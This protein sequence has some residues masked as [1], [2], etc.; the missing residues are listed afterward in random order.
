MTREKNTP[1][2]Q[3]IAIERAV[4]ATAQQE[5]DPLDLSALS[6]NLPDNTA[7]PSGLA[8]ALKTLQLGPKLSDIE[9]K[10][11]IKQGKGPAILPLI[12][13]VPHL[14]TP[15]WK[16]SRCKSN[17]QNHLHTKEEDDGQDAD[18]DGVR[19]PSNAHGKE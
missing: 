2:A 6:A 3:N 12:A 16:G 13:V 17:T 1:T 5:V 9:R 14:T 15:T 11:I 10:A 18:S 8:D 4:R 7:G 19:A